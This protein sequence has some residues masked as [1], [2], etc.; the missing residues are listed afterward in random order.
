APER[1]APGANE[2]EGRRG[3]G[4][5]PT[6]SGEGL[7][8]S[9]SER[10]ERLVEVYRK[11][12]VCELCPLSET[13]TNVVFGAGNAD[14]ELMFVGEAPGAEEDRQGLPCVGRGGALF[15]EMVAVLG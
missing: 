8:G 13:R 7:S 3:A 14:A 15:T 5:T 11:A 6:G 1:R 10:R 2:P 4:S 9:R 12:A